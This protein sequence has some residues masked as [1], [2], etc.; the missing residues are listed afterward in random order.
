M[1]YDDRY[2]SIKLG[3]FSIFLVFVKF[4]CSLEIVA[5]LR[6]WHLYRNL[7]LKLDRI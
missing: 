6:F 3:I 1:L 7:L 4:T 5:K 2:N